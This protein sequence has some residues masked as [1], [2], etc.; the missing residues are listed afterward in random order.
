MDASSP[1]R[2]DD[3]PFSLAPFVGRGAE[4]R[5]LRA[6]FESASAG[7]G[8]V[9]L[10]GGEPGI[11]KTRTADVF[12][13]DARDAK[14]LW[15]RCHEWQGAPAYWPWIQVLRAHL[16]MLDDDDLRAQLGAGAADIA[17]VLPELRQRLADLADL[18][19][20]EP[21]Q[22]RFRLFDA[23][24]TFLIN[25]AQPHPL[26]IVLDDIHWA[27]APSLLFLHFLAESIR[28][29]RIVLLGA[30]RDFEVYRQPALSHTLAEL[31]RE[32]HAQRMT[33]RGLSPEDVG[34]F[35]AQISQS[36]PTDALVQAVYQETEGNPFF[37][38]EVIRLLGAEGQLGGQTPVTLRRVPESVREVILRRLDRLPADCN[39]ALSIASAAGREF[40]LALLARVSR[41]TADELVDTLDAAIEAQLVQKTPAIGAYR[42]S[43]ALVRETL[44]EDLGTAQ[45]MRLHAQAGQALEEIHALDLA[46][47]YADLTY[48]F[49]QAAPAGTADKALDYAIKAA[50]RATAQ[51]AWETAVGHYEMA[52]RVLELQDPRDEHRRCEV[53]LA[54]GEA[55]NR[56]GT[57]AGRIIGAGNSAETVSTFMEA[58][59]VARAA[60]LTEH[61]A[62]AAFGIVG[63][64]LS[65]AQGFN[66]ASQLM[67]EAL[68]AFPKSDNSLYIH[69]LAGYAAHHSAL[70]AIDKAPM[71]LTMYREARRHTDEAVAMARRSGKPAT[72]SY[73]LH[74]RCHVYFGPDD[75]DILR[76]DSEE[77][78]ATAITAGDE[79]LRVLA[80]FDIYQA[81]LFRGDMEAARNTIDSIQRTAAPLKI[82]YFDYVVSVCLTGQALRDGRLADADGHVESA[83]SSW[84]GGGIGT[85]QLLALR[86]EQGRVNEVVETTR[87][88]YEQGRSALMW[89]VMW[90]LALLE[91]GR[92]DEARSL[93]EEFCD[94][95]SDKQR[96]AL[97]YQHLYPYARHNV[98]ASNSDHVCGSTAHYLGILATTLERWD[99]AERHFADALEANERWGIRP[100]AAWTRYQWADMLLR[101]GDEQCRERALPLLNAALVQA[102]TMG[103]TRLIDTAQTLTDN[104][105][106]MR[107]AQPAGKRAHGL[108][109][110]EMD[111]LRLITSGHSDKEIAETLSISPRT[112]TTHVTHIL[113]KLGANTR[114][115]AATIAVR[116]GIL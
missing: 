13:G 90:I 106:Q 49:V 27:D 83:L 54:L 95:F 70:M 107:A 109:P 68:A 108:S 34:A 3:P 37:V 35:V 76:A 60:G 80:L 4:L 86:R 112:V 96:A 113:N 105:N 91:I 97:V 17:Q 57:G 61:F 7:R 44:Y 14:I 24:A 73:A 81:A 56:A 23:L 62:Q 85:W 84:P 29:A 1:R 46:P 25:A 30:F 52:L 51:V 26:V 42:F 89:R 100:A 11:G 77:A 20:M 32:Q 103:M 99:A 16:S 59:R 5:V 40:S 45:R 66:E 67:E 39:R 114:T 19:P 58:T 93:F 9:V 63:L 6:A 38:G 71:D 2:I 10:I 74:A 102:E 22:A 53:L 15:G 75:L 12:A 36:V 88:I 50:E 79:R 64:S 82:R 69:L 65:V 48:H 104:L 47:Y 21:E 92:D 111:V 98:F 87:W 78:L 94:A 116:A 33:L 72:L 18:P 28:G 8:Q 43:H 110:R 101:R 41:E 55:Q 115:E 31:S